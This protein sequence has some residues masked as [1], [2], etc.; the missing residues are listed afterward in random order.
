MPKAI[1][2]TPAAPAPV[3]LTPV[4]RDAQRL[5]VDSDL[6]LMRLAESIKKGF[7][8]VWGVPE[9]PKS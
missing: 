1:T 8:T 7:E 5:I 4:E 6:A 3:E 2:I 9:N